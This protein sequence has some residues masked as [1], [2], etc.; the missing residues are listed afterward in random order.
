MENKPELSGLV[1]AVDCDVVL[2][3]APGYET[4]RRVWNADIDQHP[5]AIVRCTRAEHAAAALR[6]CLANDQELTV[7][8]GGHNLAGTSVADGAVMIDL[9][10]MRRVSVDTDART[11]TVGA[12]CRW[13]DE[14]GRAHV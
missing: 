6:W 1:A 3:G 14:I 4:L 2:P 11:L 10:L 8:G 5:A 12:G 9:G 13:G 7:R